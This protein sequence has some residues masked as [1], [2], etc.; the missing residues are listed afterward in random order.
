MVSV[1]LAVPPSFTKAPSSVNTP[2]LRGNITLECRASGSPEPTVAWTRA[3]QP[4]PQGRS[5]QKDGVLDI[6]EVRIEDFGNYTCT[7]SNKFG[8]IKKTATLLYGT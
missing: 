5:Q 3:A 1:D 2:T 6:T 8:V 4:L 7:A